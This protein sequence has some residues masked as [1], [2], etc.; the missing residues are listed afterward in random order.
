MDFEPFSFVRSQQSRVEKEI[1]R[2]PL[3][4]QWKNNQQHAQQHDDCAILW[5][6][7]LRGLYHMMSTIDVHFVEL[8]TLIGA[9]KGSRLSKT[10]QNFNW[11]VVF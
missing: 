4:D 9:K 5:Q 11:V 8:A 2:N 10:F 6:L 1:E 7:G 3:A